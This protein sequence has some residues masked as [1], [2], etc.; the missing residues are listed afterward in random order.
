MENPKI[1]ILIVNYNSSAF[2]NLSLYALEH[3]TKSSYRVHVLDNGSCSRDF[4]N[5]LRICGQYKSTASVYRKETRLRGSEA[6]G[7]ALNDLVKLVK[8]TPY[9]CILDADATWLRRH[10]DEFL[11]ERLTNQVPVYGTQAAGN[12]EKDFPLMYAILFRT[13]EFD[14]LQIDF[15]PEPTN[16]CR[17]TGWQIREQYL[18]AGYKGGLIQ[19]RNTRQQ[20]DGPFRGVLCAEYYLEDCDSIFASHFGRGSTLGAAKYGWGS[21]KYF[22]HH[23]PGL[24]GLAKRLQGL[25]DRKRWIAICRSIIDAQQ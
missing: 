9:F 12:K 14:E 6:H 25:R 18:G 10:W 3:L 13:K 1:E 5:L 7:T 4:R 17:D 2:I 8:G 19:Y 22:V 24:S 20:K 23:I 15:R 16:P 11:I 21:E